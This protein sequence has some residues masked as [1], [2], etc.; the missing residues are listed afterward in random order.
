MPYYFLV[1]ITIHDPE[2]YGK[3]L[4]KA[5]EVFDRYGGT[6]LAVDD[7]PLAVEGEWPCTRTVL[8]SFPDRAAFEAWYHSPDYQ[9]IL[10][11]RL[12]AARCDAVL[13]KG[14]E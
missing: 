4:E 9:A 1:R 11:H 10:E 6:Y 7:E 12:A 5:G 8:I 3:Y 13:L 2:R 14:L